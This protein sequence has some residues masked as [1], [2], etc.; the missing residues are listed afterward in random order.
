MVSGSNTTCSVVFLWK[1][2]FE[3]KY[4]CDNAKL[5]TVNLNIWKL[6]LPEYIRVGFSTKIIK[7]RKG[8]RPFNL[9]FNKYDFYFLQIIGTIPQEVRPLDKT[10]RRDVW[11]WLLIPFITFLPVLLLPFFSYLLQHN[12]PS[13]TFPLPSVYWFSHHC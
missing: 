10:N 3:F 6:F 5:L 7:K 4:W 12:T 8:P 11:T 13:F 1:N 9:N 2:N